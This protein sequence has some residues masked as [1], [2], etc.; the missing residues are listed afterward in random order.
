MWF[1]D[2]REVEAGGGADK[3]AERED[4]ADREVKVTMSESREV[5]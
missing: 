5:L 2:G 1:D 3:D 4:E